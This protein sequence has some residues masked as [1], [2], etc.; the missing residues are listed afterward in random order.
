[1]FQAP[2]RYFVV[3]PYHRFL[4]FTWDLIQCCHFWLHQHLRK[5]PA[6]L[7]KSAKFRMPLWKRLRSVFPGLWIEME[8]GKVVGFLWQTKWQGGRSVFLAVTTRLFAMGFFLPRL[9]NTLGLEVFVPH[10]KQTLRLFLKDF[11]GYSQQ[12]F[13]SAE[14][15]ACNRAGATGISDFC[16]PRR[17]GEKRFRGSNSAPERW[18]CSMI[19]F[20]GSSWG[21]VF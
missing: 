5:K 16:S 3:N 13:G 6:P 17:C 21:G 19:W 8:V 7:Q 14:P 10:L 18:C 20:Q 2:S 1:M 9:P 15:A 12:S 4:F 11:Q